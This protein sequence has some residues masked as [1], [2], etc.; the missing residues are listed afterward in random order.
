MA[1]SVSLKACVS[2]LALSFIFTAVSAG[3]LHR[4]SSYRHH[5]R[6]VGASSGSTTTT[7]Q[8]EVA[9]LQSSFN[10]IS[11]QVS[12]W[13]A[14]FGAQ[15]QSLDAAV[16]SSTTASLTTSTS[17]K[18]RAPSPHKSKKASATVSTLLRS[19]SKASSTPTATSTGFNAKATDN[20]AVYYGQTAD[21]KA[22]GLLELCSSPSVDV[23]NVAFLY[24]FFGPG[25]YPTVGFGPSCGGSNSEQAAAGATG[26]VSCPTLGSEITQCQQQ[27]GKVILLSMGGY[28]A[29][30][31]FTSAGQATTFANTVWNLFGAGT[32]LSSALR[33]FG[34]A[35]VDGF[36]IDNEDGL[37]QYYVDFA[38]E[39]RRLY[40][41]A[42]G[43][44][45]FYLSA[46]PQCPRPDASIPEQLMQTL[47]DFVFVQFYNNPSCNFDL[48]SAGFLASFKAWSDDLA[49]QDDAPRLFIGTGAWAGAG[50][51]YVPPADL[52]AAVAGA[53]KLRVKNLG[54]MMLWDGTEGLLNT[55]S[56][57]R[58]YMQVAKA[59]LR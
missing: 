46:A 23:I 19:T 18:H 15:L 54:G 4:H 44:R 37:P 27:Y 30:S 8:A 32:A 59:A 14:S 45:K 53:R 17:T 39:L 7:L 56:S 16:K 21:T 36:D 50:S 13:L 33:P 3:H 25:G 24:Q 2:L 55:D 20:V 51:G 12:Q 48:G 26:L 29:D 43:T 40:V 28:L 42:G 41:G 31:N 49:A 58:S 5:P 34:N 10:T 22:G 1:H 38:T 57:G 47:A 11:T 35:I 52:A 9:Q 6:A